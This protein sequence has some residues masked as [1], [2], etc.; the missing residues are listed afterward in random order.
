[1]RSSF[2]LLACVAAFVACGGEGPATKHPGSPARP[3]L[4]SAELRGPEAFS[5]IEDRGARAQ[6]L[7]LEASKVLLHP[8]CVNCHPHDDQPR[9]RNASVIHDPPVVRGPA[10]RG[11]PALEC[12]SCHQEKNVE[13]TR[14]PGAPGWHLATREMAWLG[15]TPGTICSQLKDPARNGNRSLAQIVDHAAHDPLVA[16]GWAPGADRA[17]AP[18][19][20]E[21]FS[22]LIDAWAKSGAAC[23]DETRTGGPR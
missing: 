3:P 10:D 6:A 18:G 17:P 11:V 9:Q 5:S 21:R 13:G 14:V 12:G 1:M 4:S 15:R 22:A 19:T 16:W 7:F 2:A 20:Q 23:P 8:R